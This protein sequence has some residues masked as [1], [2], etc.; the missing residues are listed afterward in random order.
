MHWP[1]LVL[2]V[3][4]KIVI[5][6]LKFMKVMQK[7]CCLVSVCGV[8]SHVTLF[9]VVELLAALAHCH[10]IS[11]D[12]ICSHILSISVKYALGLFKLI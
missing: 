8:Q 10:N 2:L 3:A 5:L 12:G 11:P 6:F 9:H 1:L 4:L 7:H